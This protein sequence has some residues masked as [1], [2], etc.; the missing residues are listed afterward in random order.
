MVCNIRNNWT[1]ILFRYDSRFISKLS[2]K[3]AVVE[4]VLHNIGR[5]AALAYKDGISKLDKFLN[6]YD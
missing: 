2:V 3:L 6:T 1:E 4:R 5:E